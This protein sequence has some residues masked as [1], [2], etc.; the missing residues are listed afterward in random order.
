[1][2]GITG[3]YAF[4]ENDDRFVL[5]AERANDRLKKRGPDGGKVYV[6][7]GTRRSRYFNVECDPVQPITA[8]LL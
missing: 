6:K 7:H 8:E 3:V 2:C 4:R 1:M 5:Q